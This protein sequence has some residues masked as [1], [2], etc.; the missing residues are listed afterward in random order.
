VSARQLED[1]DLIDDVRRALAAGGLDPAGLV[2]EV[3]E[4][5]LM[6]DAA[7]TAERLDALKG[8]GVRIA[9]DDFGTGY[10]SLAYLRQFPVDAI[11]IDRTFVR[12]IATS[13]ESTALVQILVRLGKALHLETLA[14]GIEERAQLAVLVRQGCDRGQGFLFAPALAADALD[15]LLAQR[16]HCAAAPVAA[17]ITATAGVAP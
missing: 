17:A 12:G 8:L 6:R 16:G 2:L 13:P 3:T 1:D 5:V 11:K 14:E 10:S 15:A 7:A 4:T 9:I